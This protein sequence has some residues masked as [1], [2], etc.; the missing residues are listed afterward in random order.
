MTKTTK[1]EF[2][3]L[4]KTDKLIVVDFFAT[5]CGPC[6]MMSSPIEE[7]TEEYDKNDK[8]EIVKIDIDEIPE[9]PA[10]YSVMSVPTFLFIKDEKEIDR[11]V[12]AV[13]K[14]TIADKIKKFTGE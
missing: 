7:I 2:D 1:D 5:W 14:E 4:I 12:G 3:E 6:Q 9:I 8:V 13:P 10:R 11:I